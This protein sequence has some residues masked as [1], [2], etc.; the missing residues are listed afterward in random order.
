VTDERL[1]TRC[2]FRLIP[3]MLVLFLVNYLDRVN[4]AF[5]A[6]TMNRDL[7]FSPAV[8]GFGAGV[9]FLGYFAFHVPANLILERVGARRWMFSILLVWG[10]LSAA[11]ALVQGPISFY[12]L[13][14]LLGAAES[15]L[16]PGLIYYLTLWFP[17][18]YRA[19]Y[20]ANFLI[21]LPLAFVIGA[22]LSTLLLELDGL[23]GFR[24]WQWMFVLEGLPACVLA[25]VVLKMMPDSPAQAGWLSQAE[26]QFIAARLAAQ[27]PPKHPRL[28]QAL[29]DKRV[30][31]L[32]LI[33]LAD[34]S[35]AS[36]SRFWLPQIVQGM[37][38][39][40]LLT[41]VIVALPFVVAMGA[42]FLWGRSSDLREERVWH[43]AIPL[44]LTALGFV[45]AMNT[46]STVVALVAL[47]VSMIGPLMFLGPFWGFGAA[48]L[49]G[50][51]AAGAIA[52]VSALG[53]L[54]GFIGPNVVGVLREAT[55]SYAPGI[56]ALAVA[57]A[58]SAATVFALA[59]GIKARGPALARQ[60]A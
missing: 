4:V 47:S 43:V 3:L 45:I 46:S 48:F 25:F 17:P 16:Y 15:G 26:K 29:S 44:L 54:G 32:G 10:V 38:F 49:G 55:A 53:S 28:L 51:A 58:V 2:A 36:G 33:Y 20:V 19:R 12:V 30:I 57:L 18:E 60:R 42:M 40:N 1:F 59:R 21:G 7:N 13:R 41:G 34:Q 23:L 27:E 37:G 6:L 35:A 22:P 5:A 50:R 24:G 8:Y 56:I 39:S 31:A 9:L 14:F 11:T 52:V